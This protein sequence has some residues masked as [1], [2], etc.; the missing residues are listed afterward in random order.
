LTGRS[1][2]NNDAHQIKE[3]QLALFSTK[4]LKKNNRGKQKD[5]KTKRRKDEKTKRYSI[6]D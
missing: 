5:E 2:G 6:T 1:R 3:G 4:L